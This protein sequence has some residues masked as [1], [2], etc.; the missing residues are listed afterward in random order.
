MMPPVLTHP[1]LS[2]LPGVRHAFFTRE[3]G[4]STG[5][6]QG[7]NVGRGSGDDR[8]AVAENRRR[9]AAV[10]GRE[11]GDLLTCHQIHSAVA[12]VATAPFGETRP[13]GDAVVTKRSGLICGALTADCAPILLADA[14]A[15][16]VAAVHAGWK[17]ALGG[18]IEAAV[19]AMEGEGAK[20]E[21]IV[22]VVGP[23]I[24]LNAYEVG[25]EFL[26]RFVTEDPAASAFFH[27]GASDDKRQFDLTG[28]VLSR[29]A[30]SGVGRTDALHLDTYAEARFFSNRRAVHRQEC[31]YGRLLS[32]IML[33]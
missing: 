1:L 6:Y 19:A 25:L 18:I 27:P 32:A 21:R 14:D 26:E 15:R 16:V 10:F 12:Q 7:L 20:A 29:V 11:E 17:G 30:R 3:G 5:I 22:A 23:C 13:E 4:V 2:G 33:V 9:A 24:G 8:K 28:Y 31:D